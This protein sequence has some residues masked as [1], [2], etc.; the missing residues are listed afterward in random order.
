M[1]YYFKLATINCCGMYFFR[2][3]LMVKK[4]RYY[5]RFIVVSLLLNK[6]DLVKEL[7]QV[8]YFLIYATPCHSRV[9]ESHLCLVCSESQS[10]K[11]KFLVSLSRNFIITSRNMLMCMKRTTMK[12]GGW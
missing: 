8:L 4:L 2:P 1:N 6:V 12:N 3:D 11:A 10:A 5:A 7:I 9:S